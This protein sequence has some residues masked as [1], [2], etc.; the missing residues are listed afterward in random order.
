MTKIVPEVHPPE[1]KKMTFAEC[2]LCSNPVSG[3]QID[4]EATD[5]VVIT[6]RPCGCKS[7]SCDDH[8]SQFVEL[9]KVSGSLY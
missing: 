3:F 6:L 7:H 9:V 5:D 2:P 8:Y 1:P 4:A